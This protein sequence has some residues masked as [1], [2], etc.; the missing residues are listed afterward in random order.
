MVSN[1]FYS[2][3]INKIIQILSREDLQGSNCQGD[4]YVFKIQLNPI[5][6]I[7]NFD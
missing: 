5:A 3:K 7:N 2:D 4:L 6:I 1:Y